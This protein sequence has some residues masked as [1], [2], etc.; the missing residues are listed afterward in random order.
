MVE[1]ET[2]KTLCT[3]DGKDN[4]S[5]YQ[6]KQGDSWKCLQEAVV[7]ANC[8]FKIYLIKWDVSVIF[9]FMYNLDDN[10]PITPFT[11]TF[12]LFL[13]S[14]IPRPDGAQDMIGLTVL[15]EPCARQS[16]P[17]VLDLQLR[18]ISKQTT[19]KQIVSNN[20]SLFFMPIYYD[21][22][23]Q[24]QMAI[25]FK[26]KIILKNELYMTFDIDFRTST[27]FCLLN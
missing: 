19:A 11:Y 4:G 27:N 6:F 13:Y 14:Q 18:A 17:T 23:L 8:N 9:I 10:W 24:I 3:T 20:T 7:E 16:D 15:D 25:N 26:R 5:I 21:L 22:L 2:N 12:S 1:W